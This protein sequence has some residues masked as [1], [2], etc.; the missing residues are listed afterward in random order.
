MRGQTNDIRRKQNLVSPP[1]FVLISTV[2]V[3]F[4]TAGL[5]AVAHK[6]LARK[7]TEKEVEA[8]NWGALR[9]GAIHALVLALTFAEVQDEFQD[10]KDA[11][12]REGLVLLHTATLLNTIDDE[13]AKE[14]RTEL[15]EYAETLIA[16][17]SAPARTMDP[18]IFDDLRYSKFLA[19]V[20]RLIDEMDETSQSD[21]LKHFLEQFRQARDS[22]IINGD[23]DGYPAFW[24]AS[25]C[26]FVFTCVG[27]VVHRPGA[28]AS[29]SIAMFGGLNGA[30]LSGI[31]LLSHPFGSFGLI[32][33]NLIALAL[34][35]L[36]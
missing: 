28:V 17:F 27:F 12:D 19:D 2:V 10:L 9:I 20:D 21:R 32:E 26:G 29:S 14:I 36:S 34:D 13:G 4:I 1:F 7:F 15:S 23:D 35:R 6:V 8:A 11:F 3:A 18:M 33:P 30:M 31:Y 5:H 16:S 22:R 24:F 25:I